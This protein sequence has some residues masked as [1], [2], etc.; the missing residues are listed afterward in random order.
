[1]HQGYTHKFCAKISLWMVGETRLENF[2]AVADA[3]LGDNIV[4]A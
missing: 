3:G 1:M 4:R 2:H